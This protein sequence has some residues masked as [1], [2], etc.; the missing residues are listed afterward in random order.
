MT[1]VAIVF[2]CLLYLL[3]IVM[4]PIRQLASPC[5]SFLGLLIMSMAK[6]SEGY[7][8]LPINNSIIFGWLC[9]TVVVSISILIQTPAMR[10]SSKGIWYMT[11]GAFA[12]LAIGLLGFSIA[13]QLGLL[14]A[15]MIIAIAAG[16][17][18]GFLLYVKTPDGRKISPNS[19]FFFRYLLAKGFP[20][21]ITVMQ[22]GVVLLL[23][24]AIHNLT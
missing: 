3:S 18:F 15:I 21:A 24:V 14:Y 5:C 6:T 4:L 20:T 7:Q 11:G 10:N 2:S 23:V 13:S 16:T 17:F 22:I 12:G 1:V 9:I 19:G 8:L